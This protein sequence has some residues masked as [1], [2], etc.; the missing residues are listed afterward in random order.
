MAVIGYARVSTGDQSLDVQ[1]EQLE[2]C[3]KVYS[4]II[5]AKSGVRPQMVACLEYLREGD[6]LMV[7]RL[8]R[9][10]RSTQDLLGIF[11]DLRAREI[12]FKCIHQPMFNFDAGSAENA[13][14]K[15]MLTVFSA[16]ADFETGLR[17]ERQL[18]GI[19]KAKSEGKYKGGLRRCTDKQIENAMTA[20]NGNKTKAAKELGMTYHGLLK[21]TKLCV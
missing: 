1:S 4:E 12:G 3:D 18:E 8:D 2:K 15:L 14:Q 21:R 6:T 20:N 17:R 13:S 11:D 16:I 7:C 19:A 9:L 10:G 5:G